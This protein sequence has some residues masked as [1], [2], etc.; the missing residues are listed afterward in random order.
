MRIKGQIDSIKQNEKNPK[1]FSIRVGDNWFSIFENDEECRFKNG[2]YINEEYEDTGKFKNLKMPRKEVDDSE[3][4]EKYNIKDMKAVDKQEGQN[5][6]E[7]TADEKIRSMA[8]SYAK[9]VAV[10]M[11]GNTI[12]EGDVTEA[13]LE[14]AKKFYKYIKNG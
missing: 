8:L 4:R 3:E 13:I 12:A 5:S 2:Q 1:V 9:D 6:Y 10:A 7:K 11:I 14:T